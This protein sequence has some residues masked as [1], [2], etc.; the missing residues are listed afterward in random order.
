MR[1]AG[2]KR[3]SRQAGGGFIKDV[4]RDALYEG[5][6]GFKSDMS[7][8][9]KAI[10]TAASRAKEAVRKAVKRKAGEVLERNAKRA[11]RDIFGPPTPTF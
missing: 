3:Y 5:A 2:L 8:P 6:R 4:L 7:N 1:G 9:R 11:I 10:R